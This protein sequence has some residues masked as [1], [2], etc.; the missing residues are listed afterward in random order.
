MEMY[1]EN[2]QQFVCEY[3]LVLHRAQRMSIFAVRV[4]EQ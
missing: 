1:R 3:F 4:N 2:G